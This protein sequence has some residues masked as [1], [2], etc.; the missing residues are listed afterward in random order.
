MKDLEKFTKKD[1][2]GFTDVTGSKMTLEEMKREIADHI[3]SCNKPTRLIIDVQFGPIKH[4]VKV[5]MP[6]EDFQ[7]KE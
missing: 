4:Y 1:W 3:L 6:N 2:K 5:F 7:M